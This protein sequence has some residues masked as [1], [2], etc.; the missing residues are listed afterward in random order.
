ML[1]ALYGM[2]VASLLYYKKFRKDIEGI[3]YE[4]NPYD[5]CVGNKTVNGKQHTLVW[6]VDDVK[7]SHVD[8]KVNDDFHKWCESKYG[9]AETGHVTVTRGKKHDYLFMIFDYTEPGKLK[10]DMR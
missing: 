9:S 10:I 2:L 8:K 3:G 5:P 4:I 7:A 1:K 6:H